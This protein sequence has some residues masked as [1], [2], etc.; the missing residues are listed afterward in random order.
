[1]NKETINNIL[2][3]L[4]AIVVIAVGIYLMA[5][6]HVLPEGVTQIRWSVDNNPM[7][8]VV[9][10]SF[11]KKN[12]DI[13]VINDP[14]ADMQTILTQ[15]AGDV[16]PDVITP[17]TIEAFRRLQRLGQLEDLTPYIEKYNIPVDK[18]RPELHD[19]VYIKG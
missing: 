2:Y 4:A 9:I 8:K 3:V 7:R 11:E 17:Y 16:P 10:E 12:P 5:T 18:I 1:M 19:F 15:L 6:Q 14:N 13:H